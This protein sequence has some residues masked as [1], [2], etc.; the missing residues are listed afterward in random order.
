MADP[1]SPGVRSRGASLAMR[2]T[3]VDRGTTTEAPSFSGT[4]TGS[5]DFGITPPRA[6]ITYAGELGR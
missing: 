1:V 4:L 5:A 6:T 3:I 2:G